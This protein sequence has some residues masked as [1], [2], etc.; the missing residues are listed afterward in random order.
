MFMLFTILLCVRVT[1]KFL[2]KEFLFKNVFF[3]NKQW[4]NMEIGL[5]STILFNQKICQSM[6]E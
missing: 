5:F 2:K 4:D 6:N 1:V 3:K